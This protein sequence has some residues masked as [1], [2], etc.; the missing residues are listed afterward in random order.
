MKRLTRML[1]LLLCLLAGMLLSATWLAAQS[2]D[3]QPAPTLVPPT[4]VPVVEAMDIDALPGESAVARIIRDGVVRVG[5]LYNEPPFGEFNIRGELS[6]FD[7]DLARSLAELWGVEV[8]FVQVTRQTTV[9]T[10]HRGVIDLLIAAQPHMRSLDSRVEFSTTYFPGTISLLV[11]NGDGATVLGHMEGRKVGVVLGTQGERAVLDWLNRAGYDFFVQTF[12]T[13]DQAMAALAGQSIDAVADS[14]VRLQR[15]ITDPT[16]VRFVEDPVEQLP[17]AVGVRRQDVNLR[18]LVNR[19]LQYLFRSGRLNEI[20][21][22]HFDGAAYNPGSLILWLN[23]PEDA[24]RPDQFPTDVPF[25]Q[26][27]VVPRLQSERR[28]RIAGL[29]ELPADASESARRLDAAHRTLVNAMAERWGVTVEFIP[30]SAE[31]ALDLV[32]S[33]QADLAIGVQP[34]WNGIDRVDYTGY[35]LMHGLQLMVETSRQITSIGGLRGRAIGFFTEDAGSREVLRA[36]AER[37]RA[38]VDDFYTVPRESDA[39]FSILTDTAINLDA[40]FGDSMRLQAHLE[41][42]PETLNLLTDGD[43]RAIWFS[44]TYRVMAVPRNDI[45]FRLLVEYTLQEL[46]E[47][48]RLQEIMSPVMRPQD[49]PFFEIWPGSSEYL[50]Y[51]LSR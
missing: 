42:N 46:A 1:A 32:A 38:I 28:V 6:G 3:W 35:Y 17:L 2:G 49:A 50:G 33:G 34:D 25:P 45:D 11:N 19:S 9:E 36:E 22:A 40:V 18:N 21:R 8:Q 20:H 39:A 29:P 31:N 14:R 5:I 26:S 51:Q 43:G 41:A 15:M 23:L 16:A 37:N 13:L 27:Y 44:R 7:A 48:G 24:P 30:N 10:L 47:E 4:L 12:L